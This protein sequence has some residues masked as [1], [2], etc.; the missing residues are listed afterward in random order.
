VTKGLVFEIRRFCVH[1][2]PGIRTT[3]FFKGCPLSCWWC[4]NPESQDFKP[5]TSVKKLA[6][7][8][9]LFGKT[10]TTG[11]FMTVNEVMAVLGRDRI[12]YDESIGGVTFSGGEPLMQ[13]RFLE[14]LLIRCKQEKLHTAVDTSGYASPAAFDRVSSLADLFLYDLKLAEDALHRKY[15]GVSNRPILRNLKALITSGKAVMLRFPVIPGIT[16]TEEN[17]FK[18]KALINSLI[19]LRKLD[20]SRMGEQ[21][22]LQINLLPYHSMAREKYRR[23]CKTNLLEE[24]P[25]LSADQLL[26]LKKEFETLEIPVH[27]GG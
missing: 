8:G 5:E 23:F 1:D 24:I 14:E 16:D 3:L 17:I 18:T 22:I 20:D 7:S 4:H 12:F 26:P 10:E 21:N 11:S 27:I 2:G 6:L 15:T 13:Q 25:D 19:R 9:N